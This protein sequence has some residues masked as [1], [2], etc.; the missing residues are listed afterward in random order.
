MYSAHAVSSAGVRPTHSRIGRPLPASKTW[1]SPLAISS[2]T[3]SAG[4]LTTSRPRVVKAKNFPAFGSRRPVAESILPRSTPRR[5]FAARS[6]IAS[7]SVLVMAPQP[8]EPATV[9]VATLWNVIEIVIGGVDEI[10]PTCVGGV[11]VEDLPVVLSK[12]AEPFPVGVV[13]RLRPVV[14]DLLLL[15]LG[16]E[17]GAVVEVEVAFARR[18]PMEVPAHS[19]AIRVELL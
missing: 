17:G 18:D 14:E 12:D 3:R 8:E 5:R 15:E 10:D 6:K 16:R 19:P 13:R 4:S 2:V 9:L 1:P 7:T 11:R